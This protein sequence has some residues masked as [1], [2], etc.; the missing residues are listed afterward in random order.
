MKRKERS[1]ILGANLQLANA[2]SSMLQGDNPTAACRH[3]IYRKKGGEKEQCCILLRSK[4]EAYPSRIT[5]PAKRCCVSRL[6]VCRFFCRPC[7][8]RFLR[9]FWDFSVLYT[10]LTTC[11][12]SRQVC[13][14]A[15]VVALWSVYTGLAALCELLGLCCACAMLAVLQCSSRYSLSACLQCRALI[16]T[17]LLCGFARADCCALLC[18]ACGTRTANQ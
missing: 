18:C 6:V 16:G 1:T 17:Y 9:S 3:E 7:R 15:C 13:V 4:L 11:A 8:C 14:L 2:K 12:G 10:W 5:P